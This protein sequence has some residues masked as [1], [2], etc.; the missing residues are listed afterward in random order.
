[1]TMCCSKAIQVKEDKENQSL[2]Q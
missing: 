2:D 1:M